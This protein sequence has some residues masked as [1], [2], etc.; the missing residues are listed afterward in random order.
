MKEDWNHIDREKEAYELSLVEEK[1]PHE[2]GLKYFKS[3]FSSSS[4]VTCWREK[5]SWKRIEITGFRAIRNYKHIV[6]EKKPHE[7]GLKCV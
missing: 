4:I 1:K 3:N 7:R 6:E 2:R 5:A